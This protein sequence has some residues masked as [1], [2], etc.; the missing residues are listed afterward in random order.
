MGW[1]TSLPDGM[2]YDSLPDEVGYVSLPDGVGYTSLPDGVAYHSVPDGVVAARLRTLHHRHPLVVVAE[3]RQ[4]EVRTAAVR[5][6]ADRQ[7]SEQPLRRLRPSAVTRRHDR[8]LE[9]ALE[10]AGVH[11]AC[12]RRAREARVVAAQRGRPAEQLTVP[13]EEVE[14]R[15]ARV[16]VD[17]ENTCRPHV[18]GDE[19]RRLGVGVGRAKR[20]HALARVPQQQVVLVQQLHLPET[21]PPQLVE[22]AVELRE[23]AGRCRPPEEEREQAVLQRVDRRLAERVP[24]VAARL[25][26]RHRH[27]VV[28]VAEP[29]DRTHVD[30]RPARQHLRGQRW[31]YT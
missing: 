31:H 27:L 24:D 3:Q 12:C 4:V 13:L 1:G 14:E 7:L 30:E 8:L 19:Q 28:L 22:V 26:H 20:H 29:A 17:G 16:L 25:R 9:A 5:L 18:V 2:G 15:V 6:R 10:R 23:R 21:Q 11:A